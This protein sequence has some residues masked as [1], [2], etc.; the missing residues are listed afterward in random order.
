MT[1]RD[2]MT[3]GDYII[4]Y[5]NIEY[6]WPY[7]PLKTIDILVPSIELKLTYIYSQIVNQSI[8]III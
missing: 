3:Y 8:D 2:I 5:R 6:M 4:V 1:D 7:N